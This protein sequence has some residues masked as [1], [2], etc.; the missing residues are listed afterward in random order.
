MFYFQLFMCE[1]QLRAASLGAGSKHLQANLH[2][3]NMATNENRLPYFQKDW[4]FIKDR[5]AK[6][7][8]SAK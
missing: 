3:T 1:M 8:V 5:M 6:H 2:H 7:D 4:F